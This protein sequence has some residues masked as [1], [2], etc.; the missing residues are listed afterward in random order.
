MIL[1]NILSDVDVLG[2]KVV[3]TISLLVCSIPQKNTTNGTRMKLGSLIFMEM[4]ES[5]TTKDL[6]WK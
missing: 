6:W 3:A 1:S 4:D 5:N 2:G